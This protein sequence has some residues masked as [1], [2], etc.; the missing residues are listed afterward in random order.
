[1]TLDVRGSLKNTGVNRNVYIVID[2][3]LSNA[4]DSYLIR[5]DQNKFSESLSVNF[6]IELFD[7][8]LDLNEVDG[9][10]SYDLKISCTDNGAGLA[11]DQTKAFVTKDTSFKDDLKIEGVGKCKGSGRIQYLH[12][13]SKL[14]VESIFFSEGLYK[15][16]TLHFTD[17]QKEI[18]ENSFIV[19]EVEKQDLKT[20]ITLNL[21]KSEIFQKFIFSLDLRE[22]FSSGTLKNYVL[23]SFLQRLVS[24]KEKLG[25]FNISFETKY[26]NNIE[27]LALA[28][29]DLPEITLTEEIEIPVNND[30]DNRIVKTEKFLISQYKLSK[31]AYDL[32]KNLV[33]L[34][35]KA[36]VV[37][38]ITK[39]YLKT[40]TLENNSLD[41]FY[42]IILVES[43]YLDDNVN[44]LRDGFNIPVNSDSKDLFL[45]NLISYEEIYDSIDEKI[46]EMLAPPDWDRETIVEGVSDKFGISP[47]MISDVDVRIKYGDSVVDVSK[48]V[49]KKYQERVIKD[50]SDIFDIR[51]EIEQL[52]PDSS[53][54]RE[55]INYLAW[56]Y[57]SSLKSID[58]TNLSQLVVRRSAMIDILFMAINNELNVQKNDDG[59]K[60][61]DEKLIHNI[62][63]PTGKDTSE[64]VDHDIWLLNEEYQYFDYISSEKALS[65]ISWDDESLLFES[66]VDEELQN[67]LQKNYESNSLKRPDIAIFN[68]E[69]AAIIIEFKAPNVNMDEHVPDLMEYS[70]LLAAKSNGKLK[71]FYGYLIG[72]SANPNRITAPYNSFPNGKGWFGTQPIKDHTTGNTLGE[73]YSE[74][75]Y[76]DDIA[77]R[78]L[79]R[80]EVYKERLGLENE[81]IV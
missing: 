40:R 75:L 33:A 81:I 29:K 44:L 27:K 59:V 71:K 21:L 68:K 18:D 78:A 51:E 23:V 50:T 73:L 8:E 34:C 4:I 69:G 39:K 28:P 46:S 31:T 36:S 5:K 22:L 26:K 49:L 24:L 19:E 45:K 57:T 16:R 77:Q 32:P 10:K 13:F 76:Y 64:V 42:H 38:P 61:K 2:E 67:I 9:H 43:E 20:S 60:R 53:D 15:K 52:E 25:E 62:F 1:M 14:D 7:K 79:K 37:K 47:S 6:Q 35:A 74:I 55:K 17:A 63:F 54:F 30:R 56:R 48:R 72:S 58:M 65:T 80:I 41:G 12:Y 11:D 3:L 66:D 70:Q